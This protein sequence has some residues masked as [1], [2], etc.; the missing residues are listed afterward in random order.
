MIPQNKEVRFEVTTFCNYKCV[1]C[2][3]PVLQREKEVM[4]IELFR[5]LFDKI[6]KETDQYNSFSFAGLGEPLLDRGLEEKVKY[7][8][9]KDFYYDIPMVT[10]GYL[11]TLDRFLAL[12]DAGVDKLRISFHGL[13][14]GKYARV[15]GVHNDNYGVVLENIKNI[16]NLEDRKTKLLITHV[17]MEEFTDEYKKDFL[18][19][20]NFNGKEPELIEA[21]SPH[22]WASSFD[23]RKVENERLNTCGRVFEGPLQVQV[24]GTVNLCCF[25][26]DG[27]LTVGSL[28]NN[29][30]E[31]IFTSE[32]YKAIAKRHVTGNFHNSNLICEKCDQR[33]AHK[34]GACLYS[35]KYDLTER[36]NLTSTSYKKIKK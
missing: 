36:T 28:K 26:H 18:E 1:F 29:T 2:K 34:A 4:P 25:D 10:N 19:L 20:F 31:E 11:L 27:A 35:S 23:Y 8:R 16:L 7:V 32:E 14:Y 17:V 30:L 5:Y 9:N 6:I 12:Q 13:T 33:N 15:H 21:W 24:D 3:N 22:N